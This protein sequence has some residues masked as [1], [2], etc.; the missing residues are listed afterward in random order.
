MRIAYTFVQYVLV[1]IIV[2]W[3]Y[4]IVTASKGS[5]QTEPYFSSQNSLCST[6]RCKLTYL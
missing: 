3:F 5:E 1:F 6:S 4:C 2:I